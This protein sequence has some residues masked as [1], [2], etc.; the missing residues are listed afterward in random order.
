MPLNILVFNYL[1]RQ[2]IKKTQHPAA[3]D[4][5]FQDLRSSPLQYVSPD[6]QINLAPN[7]KCVKNLDT[8]SDVQ[9]GDGYF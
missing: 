2:I 6:F 5:D 9:V 4:N 7:S 1:L 8:S 3:K